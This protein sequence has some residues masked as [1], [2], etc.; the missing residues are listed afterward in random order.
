MFDQ[1]SKHVKKNKPTGIIGIGNKWT[2]SIF[3]IKINKQLQLSLSFFLR[4]GRG[5]KGWRQGGC[6][7]ILYQ[8]DKYAK[9]YKAINLAKYRLYVVLMKICIYASD[10]AVFLLV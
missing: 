8:D 10:K 2:L 7:M 6:G 3:L 5:V 4:E 9:K 1:L